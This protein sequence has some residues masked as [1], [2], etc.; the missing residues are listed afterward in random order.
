MTARIV[1]AVLALLVA[2]RVHVALSLFGCPVTVSLLMYAALTVGVPLAL[3][4]IAGRH[5]LACNR[6]RI[7]WGTA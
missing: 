3:V 2:V 5:M 4:F 1:V 7:C 6:P